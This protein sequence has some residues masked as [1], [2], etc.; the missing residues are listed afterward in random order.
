MRNNLDE[1][2]NPFI[3]EVLR[4]DSPYQGHFRWV[5]QDGVS[6]HG[7]ALPKN[8]RVYISWAAANRDAS[9][10]PNPEAIDLNRPNGKQHLGFGYGVHE[11]LGAHLVRLQMRVLLR[12]ILT[13]TKNLRVE[14]PPDC[15]LSMFS[16]NYER[17]PIRFEP[18]EPGDTLSP[19]IASKRPRIR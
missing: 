3:E 1:K 18:R 15:T 7:V 14:S 9:I 19:A 16:R 12:E 10:F 8:S 17:M 11:C 5:Q 4:L 2:L 6:L 13:T